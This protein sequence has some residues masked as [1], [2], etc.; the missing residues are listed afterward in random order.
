MTDSTAYSDILDQISNTAR[1]ITQ[2][3]YELQP[4]TEQIMA[5]NRDPAI[6]AKNNRLQ[7]EIARLDEQRGKLRDEWHKVFPD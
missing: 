5:G 6:L 2:L 7:D 4:V 1:R 3:V